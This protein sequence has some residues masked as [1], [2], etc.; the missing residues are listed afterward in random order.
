MTTPTVLPYSLEPCATAGLCCSIKMPPA[1]DGLVCWVIPVLTLPEPPNLSHWAH[2]LRVWNP[3]D[4]VGYVE[5]RARMCN[6]HVGVSLAHE[7]Y[8]GLMEMGL[9]TIEPQFIGNVTHLTHVSTLALI[10]TVSAL[11][12]PSEDHWF[13]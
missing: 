7:C 8:E 1:Y 9:G 6:Q 5:P 4:E 10:G 2:S 12:S 3:V 11:V 13:V